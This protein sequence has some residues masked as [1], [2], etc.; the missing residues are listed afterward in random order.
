MANRYPRFRHAQANPDPFGQRSAPSQRRTSFAAT[1]VT[2]CVAVF[3]VTWIIT[4]DLHRV[5]ALSTRTPA[6]IAAVERS[7]TYSG[8]NAARAAGA[9]PIYR[10]T[11]GYRPEMDGDSDGIACEPIPY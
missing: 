8:C 11:P 9:A 7:V 4:P 3:A 6:E 5:W 1:V 10:G 2:G